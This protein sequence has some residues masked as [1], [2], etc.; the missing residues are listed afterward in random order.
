MVK[1]ADA[2]DASFEILKGKVPSPRFEAELLAGHILKKDKLQLL[3]CKNDEIN[4]EDF[5]G[6]KAFSQKRA[7]GTPMAYITGIREFM[8]LDFEVNENVLIPRP[9]TEELVS[10]IIQMYEGRAPK[11]LDLCTGSGA[12]CCSLAHYLKGADCVGIDISPDAIDIARKNAGQLGVADRVSFA[13]GDV[14]NFEY[15]DGEFDL[16]VSNP[17]Y[18]ETDIIESLDIGVKNHEPRLALDGGA[19]G[20]LFYRKITSDA[21]KYL[22]KG[23]MI[24]FEIGYNQGEAVTELMT[25]TFIN[26]KLI[27]DLSGND[28][29]V[30]GQL[31]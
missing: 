3:I 30:M 7:S 17:P 25:N 29:I 14:L 31:A 13:A 4:E 10:L 1:I 28:R 24:F 2:I 16:V 11:I 8:S 5:E 22:K 18:I 27:K 15:R 12:I 21:H 19:D 26:I 23:G 20:L 9:E 6:I